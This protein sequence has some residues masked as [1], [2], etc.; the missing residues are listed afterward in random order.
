MGIFDFFKNKRSLYPEKLWKVKI[1]NDQV[2]STDPKGETQFIL[3]NA[4]ESI[5]IQTNDS[6]PFGIDFWWY[7]HDGSKTIQITQGA[8]GEDEMI[9]ELQR[10]AG[11]NN[12]EFILAIASTEN[13]EFICYKN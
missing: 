10:L 6:G 1:Q 3:I 4:I 11:F 7:V 8:T 13:N 5:L 12:D 9:I 2:F